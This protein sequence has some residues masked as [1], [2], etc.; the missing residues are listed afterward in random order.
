[1]RVHEVGGL[2]PLG[3]SNISIVCDRCRCI[4]LTG[5]GGDDNH[6]VGT[7]G[8]IDG[9]GRSIFQHVD[10]GNVL[11]GYRGQVTLD[12]I[13]QD[14]WFQAANQCGDT[15]ETDARCCFRITAGI[16]NCQTGNLTFY[17]FGSVT[18]LT[19]VE[20]LSFYGSNSRGNISLTLGTVTDDN[21][22][23]QQSIV[24]LEGYIATSFYLLR[25]KANVAHDKC[26]VAIGNG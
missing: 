4:T 18:D 1:M 7:T 22:F 11:R 14:Q 17:Q 3:E 21:H 12:T 16:N 10:R 9:G 19:G 2:G 25:S 26:N 15:T 5:L 13:H 6:A 23:I 20:V 8:T 24:F